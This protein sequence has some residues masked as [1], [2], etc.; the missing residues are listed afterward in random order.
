MATGFERVLGELKNHGVLLQTDARLPNVCALVAGAPVRGSWWAHPRSHDIFRVNCAL[1]EHPDVLITKLVS[2]KVTY[3]DRAL[4][5]AIVT[6]GRAR[7]P[8]QLEC[9]SGAARDLLVEVDCAPVQT[10]RRVAKPASELEKFLLVYSQQFHTEGGAH[11]RRLESWDDW[12][13]RTGSVP[14]ALRPDQ[15][16]DMLEQLIESL[17]H[18]FNAHGRLPWH[19]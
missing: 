15:A 2:A 19:P 4:W 7:E 9:L 8:W 14:A 11:A 1:E 13:S 5:S 10:D 16:R 12:L 3:V 6:V 18:S 17:N